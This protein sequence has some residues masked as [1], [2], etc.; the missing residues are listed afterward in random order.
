MKKVFLI[1]STLLIISCEKER[2]V[3]NY[4][5]PNLFIYAEIGQRKHFYDDL[6]YDYGYI[7]VSY[8][9]PVTHT[10]YIIDGLIVYEDDF[11]GM[12]GRYW[13]YDEVWNSYTEEDDTYDWITGKNYELIVRSQL[14]N[15]YEASAT[16]QVPGSFTIN[17]N[18]IPEVLDTLETLELNWSNSENATNYRLYFTVRD[19]EFERI[20]DSTL[21]FDSETNLYQF[22]DELIN[23]PNAYEINIR[24]DAINGPPV[25]PGI[26]G[27]II[28]DGIGYFYGSFSPRT[29]TIGY[30]N[31]LSMV[32]PQNYIQIFEKEAEE[33]FKKLLRISQN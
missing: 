26:T 24:L 6:N 29:I 30:D 12:V 33:S 14:E 3:T 19:F 17:E 28:G 11:S 31:N 32:K 7:D 1:L 5:E 16:V 2:I 23:H 21:I 18:L 8:Y 25:S 22:P 10:E 9:P 20:I 4:I 13:L 27:N 15:I